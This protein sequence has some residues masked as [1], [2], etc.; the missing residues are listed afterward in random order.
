[1]ITIEK[2][3]QKVNGDWEE[4]KE[5]QK[6]WDALTND[7]G[8]PPTKYYQCIIGG[9]DTDTLIIERQWESMAQMEET[10]E[11]MFA[12][13]EFQKLNQE[14]DDDIISSVQYEIYTPFHLE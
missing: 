4:L 7:L 5:H 9:H 6:K 11:K 8:F 1:M 10:Y 2:Q 3:I 14:S 12:S 13:E